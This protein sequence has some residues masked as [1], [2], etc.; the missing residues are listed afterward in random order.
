[1]NLNYF[2]IE[3]RDPHLDLLKA[4]FQ[5]LF[6]RD[7]ERLVVRRSRRVDK[8]AD[9]LVAKNYAAIF[10][11][12]ADGLRFVG[13]RAK[14]FAQFTQSLPEVAPRNRAPVV[15]PLRQQDFVPA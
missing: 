6:E 15:K 3:G 2:N 1:M 12:P 10:P 8:N 5:R 14:P 13:D 4:V 9:D 7:K 11:L